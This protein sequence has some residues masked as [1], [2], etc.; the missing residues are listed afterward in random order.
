VATKRIVLFI[1]HKT[2]REALAC[3][4]D[5]ESDLEMVLQASSLADVGDANLD[6]N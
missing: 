2:F 3:V 5:R 6:H 4:L 1:R